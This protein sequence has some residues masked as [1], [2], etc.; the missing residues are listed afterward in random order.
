MCSVLTEV[1]DWSGGGLLTSAE[2]YKLEKLLFSSSLSLSE[3]NTTHS[4]KRNGSHLNKNIAKVTKVNVHRRSY[5]SIPDG[6]GLS[7]NLS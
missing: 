2:L 1:L 4:N 6:Y 5:P 3:L 7:S